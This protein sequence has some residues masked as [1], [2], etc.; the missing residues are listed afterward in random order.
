L[1]LSLNITTKSQYDIDFKNALN[2]PDKYWKDILKNYHWIKTP[3]QICSGDFKKV[4]MKWFEDGQLNI[5]ENLLDRHLQDKAHKTAIYFEANDPKTKTRE[6]TYQQLYTQVCQTAELMTL[7]G[8]KKGDIVCLYMSMIPELLVSVLACARIGAVHS[9]IFGGF[10]AKALADRVEDCKAK[11]IITN[12]SGFRGDKDLPIKT[13]VDEALTKLSEKSLKAFDPRTIQVMVW[14]HSHKNIPMQSDRNFFAQ[15]ELNPKTKDFK[16]AIMNAED[17]LFILYTSGSTGKPKGLVHTTAGYMVWASETFKNVF[18]MKEDSDIYWCTADIGWITGHSYITY[19]PLIN[20]VSQVMF[21]GIP[22]WP[23]AGRFWQTV[24]KYKVTHFYTAPTAIRALQAQDIKFVKNQNLSSLKVL[25]T[26]GEPINE[27]A[28]H[29]YKK[30]I[31]HNNCPIVDTWWQTET[32]GIMISNLA[33]LTPERPSFATLPLPAVDAVLLSEKSDVL[34]G[35]NEGHLCIRTPWPGM[36]RTILGDHERYV[37]TYFSTHKGFYFTGDGAKRTSNGDFRII[38]RVDDVV[39]VSGH[40][41]GTAEVEDV[42]DE[43]K[44]VK[45][46]AV[47]GAHHEVKGQCLVAFVISDKNISNQELLTAINKDLTNEMGAICKVD[48][49]YQVPGLPKTRSGKIMRRILRKMADGETEFG[50]ISTLLNPEVVEQILADI[51]N[52]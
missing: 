11:M 15:E 3:E 51:K 7:K 43:N 24:D 1:E 13:V 34:D 39:N 52:T 25:G 17:P 31:G 2:H 12:D 48:R 40:R 8:I 46:A 38:G 28:W 37:Q 49:L 50:D 4:D 45:E 30:E 44:N 5:T 36:A 19:G 33:G 22:T 26:V 6:L 47:I 9:V 20:G 42:I 27:E 29:W 32:G 41:I 10:S 23:D 21:E 35:E 18:Q 16:P 14:K